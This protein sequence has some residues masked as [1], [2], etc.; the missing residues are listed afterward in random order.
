M[1][2]HLPHLSEWQ[3]AVYDTWLEQP[4]G[5]IFI[6]KSIRQVGKS[7]LA[8]VLLIA[9]S[10]KK[11]NS[12]SYLIEPVLSQSRKMYEEV[13]KIADKLI[14][15]ANGA[16]LEI[17]FFNGSKI[18]FRSEEQGDAIRGGTIKGS[19]ILI[20]DEAAFIDSDFFYSICLPM[21]NVNKSDVF[22]FSTPKFKRGFFYELFL[23]GIDQDDKKCISFDWTTYDTSEYL[24][25]ETLEVYRQQLPRLAFQCEFMGEWI[26][27]EGTVFSD[28]KECIGDY[29]SNIKE[30][31]VIGIDWA[32]GSGGDD[33]V[34]TA[35]Q[36]IDEKIQIIKIKSFNDK[37]ANDTID[38]ILNFIKS[39]VDI[40]F[41]EIHIIC[42]KNSIGN[43]FSDLLK[44]KVAEYE[45]SYNDID[46]RNQIGISVQLFN[47]SN[48]SKEKIIK[49]LCL[50]FENQ[51][52]VIPNNPKLLQQLAIYEV[53][54][55]SAGNCIYNAPNKADAHDDYVMSLAILCNSLYPQLR[56]EKFY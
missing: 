12:V 42:E 50:L 44:S 30:R 32:T 14:Q 5:K 15:K 2:I 3:R 17:T 45:D 55:S 28:F 11:S 54:V 31:L 19:G 29:T 24:D 40:G 38:I 23:R 25:K 20:L 39:F 37:N 53:K 43:V 41:K 22:L 52:I 27:G 10:C 48:S 4:E 16:S 35:G 6:T 34:L 1:T 51:K 8:C 18:R 26:D 56:T 13:Y 47:T 7:A 33:T 49:Q 21:T 36:V 9:A 46:W